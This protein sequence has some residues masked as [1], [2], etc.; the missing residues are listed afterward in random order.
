VPP[1]DRRFMDR[2]ASSATWRRRPGLAAMGYGR[3]SRRQMGSV[4]RVGR[5]WIN[6]RLRSCQ[7]GVIAGCPAKGCTQIT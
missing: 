4:G 1:N 6:R 3:R 2:D 7:E 5:W